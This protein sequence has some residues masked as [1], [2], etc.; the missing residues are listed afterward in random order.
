MKFSFAQNLQNKTLMNLG[1]FFCKKLQKVKAIKKVKKKVKK[2]L[3]GGYAE[4][5]LKQVLTNN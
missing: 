2:H 5:P 4:Y 1:S 3:N